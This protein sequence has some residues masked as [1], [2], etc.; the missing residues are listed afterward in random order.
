MKKILL[1]AMMVLLFSFSANAA[2]VTWEHDGINTSGYTICWYKTSEPT[3]I[4]VRDVPGSTVRSLAIADT[5]FEP[6]VEYT[7]YGYAYNAWAQSPKSE[8][9]TWTRVV[10][11]YQPPPNTDPEDYPIAPPSGLQLKSFTVTK[12]YVPKP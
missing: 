4:K 3:A 5:E 6:N 8:T 10:T 2:T 12:T 1:M 11:E 9:A 7:F